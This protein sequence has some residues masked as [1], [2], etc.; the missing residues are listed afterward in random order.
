MI[1]LELGKITAAVQV[2]DTKIDH[3]TSVGADHEQRL[4]DGERD[5]AEM[6]ATIET[7]R[8][9]RSTSRDVWART[10]AGLGVAGAVGAAVAAYIHH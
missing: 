4:R 10:V 5:R 7:I 1:L 9:E 6:H 8:T 3:L 2:I